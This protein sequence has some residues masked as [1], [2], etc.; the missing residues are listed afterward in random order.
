MLSTNSEL[1]ELV[2][3]PVL[4]EHFKEHQQWDPSLSI[5]GF[6]YMHYFQD[7]NAYGDQQR[8]MEMPFKTALHSATSFVWFII[9]SPDN[10]IVSKVIYQKLDQTPIINDVDYS[11]QY[12]S[13]IWQPPRFC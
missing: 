7:D 8:D 12:L 5:V 1:L 9:P 2:K 6:L 4:V 11:V 10:T 13:S 3:L